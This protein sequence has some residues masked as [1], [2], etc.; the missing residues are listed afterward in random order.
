MVKAVVLAA[1]VGSRLRPRTLD[2]PKALLPIGPGGETVLGRL[3]AQCAAAGI[4]E[5]IL[6]TGH[7]EAAVRN[8]LETAPL[9]VRTVFNPDY[10]R[11]NNGQSLLV[12]RPL[13]E[14]ATFVKFDG[15]LVLDAQLLPRLLAAAARSCI[16]LDDGRPLVE[17]DMKAQVSAET[18]LV[19]AFGKHL[20]LDA[21]GISIGAERLHADDAPVVFDALERRIHARGGTDDYYEDAYDDA[22]REGLALGC[23]RTAGLYWTEI[24]TQEELDAARAVAGK[25]GAGSLRT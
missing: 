22:L 24:D 21:T 9:P 6:V 11:M 16:L 15:D 18:G 1:G 13:V 2:I 4:E 7:G 10:A 3:L 25:R 17:E 19:T 23:V 5:A 8:H 20:P 14:G 12:V